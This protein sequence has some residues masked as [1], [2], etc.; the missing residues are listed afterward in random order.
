MPLKSKLPVY[1][2]I[3]RSGKILIFK[4]YCIMEDTVLEFPEMSPAQKKF[5]IY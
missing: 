1:V 3:M 4:K 2:P 5:I